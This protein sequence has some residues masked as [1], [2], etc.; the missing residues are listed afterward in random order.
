MYDICLEAWRQT[1]SNGCMVVEL[2][3]PRVRHRNRDEKIQNN[4]KESSV[5]STTTKPK[6]KIERLFLSKAFKITLK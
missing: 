2:M 3:F 6:H 5:Y 4:I 1:E